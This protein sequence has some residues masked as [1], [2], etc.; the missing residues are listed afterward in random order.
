MG[1]DPFEREAHDLVRRIATEKRLVFSITTGRSGTEYLTRALAL[2]QSVAAA[3]EPKPRFS[4]VWRAVLCAED[5][6]RVARE[7]WVREKLPRIARSRKPVYAETSHL[8]CKGF[9]EPLV[10]LGII[11]ELVHLRRDPRL[12]AKSMWRLGAIPGRTLRGAKHFLSPADPNHLPVPERA[13]RAFD[14]YQ[15]CY[16]T[17]LEMDARAAHLR[18]RLEPRGVRVHPVELEEIQSEEGLQGLGARLSLGPLSTFGRMR[19]KHL[20]RARV[21][22]KDDQKRSDEPPAERLDEA[23]REVREAVGLQ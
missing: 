6:A 7:F 23:E 17:C 4:G 19:L 1:A 11:P 9:L 8:A 21:N 18:A 10:A 5:R 20:A 16:W 15:L 12:V 22:A 14:D 3:H 2:F 13:S